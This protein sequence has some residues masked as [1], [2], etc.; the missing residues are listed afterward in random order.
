MKGGALK[1][2]LTVNNES[3][4]YLENLLFIPALPLKSQFVMILGVRLEM[5]MNWNQNVIVKT[6]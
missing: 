2:R 4:N 1:V 6:N 5:R 3:N